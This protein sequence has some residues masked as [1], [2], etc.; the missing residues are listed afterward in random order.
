MT[1]NFQAL[2]EPPDGASLLDSVEKAA[3]AELAYLDREGR[4]AVRPVTPVNFEGGAA[5]TLTYA[6]AEL[7]R[8]LVERPEACLTLSDSRLAYVG[9]RP[10]SVPVTLEAVPDLTGDLYCDDIMHQELRKY[11]PGRRLA[12]SFLLRR[13]HWWYLPRFI[14]RMRPE[15]EARTVGRKTS[16]DHA[17]LA[18]RHHRGYIFSETVKA[19]GADGIKESQRVEVE[20]LEGRE[21]PSGG[22]R[23]V[24]HYHDFSVPDMEQRISL[25]ATGRLDG[26]R[27]R[28]EETSGAGGSLKP[29]GIIARWREYRS[30]ERDC[31]AG[32]EAHENQ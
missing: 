10:L 13:E 17:V 19:T 3:V 20:P 28:I 4:P 11:P 12:N 32:I 2:P 1:S 29:A 30:L 15:S 22:V 16:P 9:W 27:L 25:N 18:W 8:H 26:G 5:F 6:D 21:L 31:R 24:L 23:A 14:F 7:A